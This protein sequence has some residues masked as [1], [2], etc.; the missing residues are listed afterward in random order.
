MPRSLPS[1]RL[2][3]P[4]RQGVVTLSGRDF[5]LGPYGTAASRAE[6]DRLIAEW[7]ANGRRLPAIEDQ[8]EISV[9]ELLVGYLTFAREYYSRDGQPT[10]EYVEMQSVSKRLKKL[11]GSTNVVDFGPLS[12]KSVRQT[13]IDEQH[14]RAWINRQVNRIRRIFK[15]GVENEIVPAEILQ[16][17]QAVAPLKKGRSAA[18]EMPPVK[19]V[20]EEHVTA[21]LQYVSPQVAAMIRLQLLTGMRPGEVVLMRPID[22]DRTDSVW[23]YRPSRHKTDY[24]GQIREVFL[25]P[26]CQEILGPFLDRPPEAFCFSPQEAEEARNSARRQAR[27]TPFTPSQQARKPKMN[28]RRK[29]RPHYDRD[30]YRRAIEYGIKKAAVPHWHP[31]QLRHNCGTKVRKEFGLDVAQVILG[32][33]TAAVTEVYAEADRRKATDVVRKIG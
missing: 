15:W 20:P 11:Y 14:S 27:K 19:P 13:L 16:A 26:Q 2:H 23:V 10:S 32:H 21:V 17:L 8:H 4:S 31:H 28:S 24:R 25:G 3:R 9:V 6:Y 22:V 29:K 33:R 18:R 30:S 12:L 7:L 1:Y 5:Y